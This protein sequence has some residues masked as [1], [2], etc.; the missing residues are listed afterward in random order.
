M[1]DDKLND[2]RESARFLR[3]GVSTLDRHVAAGLIT[4]C[5][6]GGRVFFRQKSL[7]EFIKRCER[8]SR[9]RARGRTP[10]LRA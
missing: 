9:R 3:I 2:K 4:A 1:I 8:K 7:E 5:R 10:Q 6:I